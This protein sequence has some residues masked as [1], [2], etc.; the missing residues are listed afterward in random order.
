M[1]KAVIKKEV[2]DPLEAKEEEELQNSMELE[3][4]ET[5]DGDVDEEEEEDGDD[6]DYEELTMV[7]TVNGILDADLVREAVQRDNIKL[8]YAETDAPVLQV[9]VFH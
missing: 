8:R 3:D 4:V 9:C 2:E 1:L 7:V 5:R 6:E